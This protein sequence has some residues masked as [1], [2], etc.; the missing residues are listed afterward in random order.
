MAL[1][2]L[3]ERRIQR[4]S[5]SASAHIKTL[6][7]VHLSYASWTLRETKVGTTQV[8]LH[9]AKLPLFVAPWMSV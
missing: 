8:E 2:P 7:Q 1:E 4:W 6:K 5:L 9:S 3:L